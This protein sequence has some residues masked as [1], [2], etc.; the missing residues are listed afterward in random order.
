MTVEELKVVI[1]DLEAAKLARLR[2]E[3]RLK[4]AYEGTIVEKALPTLA[5]IEQALVQYRIQLARLTGQPTGY[6][7]IAVRFGGRP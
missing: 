1:A 4:V 2:G 7:P 5:E 3:S 6:G